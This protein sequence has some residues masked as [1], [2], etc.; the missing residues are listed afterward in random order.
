MGKEWGSICLSPIG[1]NMCSLIRHI[2][3]K[4]GNFNQ[5]IYIQMDKIPYIG[6]APSPQIQHVIKN[7]T[8]PV[9]KQRRSTCLLGTV[10][11]HTTLGECTKHS[12]HRRF[13]CSCHWM[14]LLCSY[15]RCKNSKRSLTSS[16]PGSSK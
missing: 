8:Q 6:L 1:P 7:T 3:Y 10:R 11:F 9:F 12:F 4:H 13:S 5:P 16:L 14:Y 2:N 15:N